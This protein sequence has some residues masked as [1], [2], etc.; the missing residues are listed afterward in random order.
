VAR[1]GGPAGDHHR[2]VARM[3]AELPV[4]APAPGVPVVPMIRTLALVS[5]VCGFAVTL[6]YQWTKPFVLENQRVTTERAVRAVLPGAATQQAFALGADGAVPAA[7]DSPPEDVVY[8]GYDA[9]GRIVGIAARGA[10]RGYA[11]LVH[12]M[13][14]YDPACQCINAVRVT[15]MSET[16]GLGDAV[17]KDPEFQKNFVALDARVNADGTGLANRI[18][19]VKHG[20]KREAWQIDAISGSTVTSKAIG[21]G[22]D[23]SAQ[24][25]VPRIQR[26]LAAL[27]AGGR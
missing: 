1:D 17:V 20:T 6:A 27:E 18:V 10:A 15:K 3:S 21:R 24:R 26:H 4:Q 2:E 13:Y 9:A 7:A 25:L 8:V 19:T 5:L 16:P 12:V 23:L 14:A 22:L 11:D